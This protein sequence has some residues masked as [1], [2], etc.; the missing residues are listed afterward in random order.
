MTESNKLKLPNKIGGG[1]KWRIEQKSKQDIF[2][3]LFKQKNQGYV[4]VNCK[5][6][7]NDYAL[8]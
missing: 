1:R 2:N 5:F 3:R 6:Y 7:Y 4:Q 8:I